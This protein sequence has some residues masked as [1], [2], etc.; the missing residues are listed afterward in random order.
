[1]LHRR[2]TQTARAG[3]TLIELLVVIAIIAI[4]IGLLLP[5]VQKVR[6]AAARMRCQ[7]NIKQLGLAFH[8]Y[9]STNGHFTPG[10]VYAGNFFASGFSATS[11]EVTWVTLSLPYLEQNALYSL[12]NFSENMGGVN[13]ATPT[14]NFTVASTFLSVMTCPS[15]NDD[16]TLAFS[17]YARGNYVANFGIG[18]FVSVH[19]SPSPTNT[20]VAPGPVGMNSRWALETISDGTSNTA[21][22]SEIIRSTGNDVRG[23]MHYPEGPLYTHNFTPGDLTPDLT[24]NGF[25]STQF[26]PATTGHSAWSD[27]NIILTARSRHTGGANTAFCDGSVRFIRNNINLATWRALGTIQQIAGEIIPSDF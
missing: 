20:V 11:N 12:V 2:F 7:N 24:R 16:K 19:T 1:M 4:L 25:V 14:G 6:E 27:R 10:T 21:L 26:A 18:P 3:F 17:S 9:A 13:P 5:A 22:V 23:I 8:N 15:D